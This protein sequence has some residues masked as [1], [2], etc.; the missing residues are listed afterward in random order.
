MT[1]VF[2]VRFYGHDYDTEIGMWHML[3][4]HSQTQSFVDFASNAEGIQKAEYFI[5]L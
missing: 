1:S 4:P 5:F 2:I 3:M